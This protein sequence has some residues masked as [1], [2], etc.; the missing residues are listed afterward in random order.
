MKHLVSFLCIEVDMIDKLNSQL[1]GPI[2]L[3]SE[4]CLKNKERLASFYYSNIRSCA[5]M[6]SFSFKDAELKIESLIGHV[7]DGSAM[8]FGVFDNE[9]LIGYVWAYRH[10]FREE[11]RIYV[12]EIHV[13]EPYRGKGVG[14]Q[15]LS[16]VESMAK[17]RGFGAT[18]LHAEGNNEGAICFYRNQGYEIERVQVRKGL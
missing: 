10:Q 11:E 7:S 18:Y 17:E 6:D 9:E 1:P 8:V 15:L 12:N 3:N 4:L 14:K 5:Y 2:L 13:A 16:A